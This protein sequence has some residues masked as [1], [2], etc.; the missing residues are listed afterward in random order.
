MLSMPVL[1]LTN[2]VLWSVAVF[3]VLKE[4]KREPRRLFGCCL[5]ISRQSILRR[6]ALISRVPCSTGGHPGLRVGCS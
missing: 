3:A 6:L 2:V 5:R 1:V 4:A